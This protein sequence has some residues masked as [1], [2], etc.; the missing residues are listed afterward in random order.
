MILVTH[1]YERRFDSYMSVKC[2]GIW[3][4]YMTKP[5]YHMIVNHM[6]IC[7]FLCT[8]MIRT[9]MIHCR[10][11][12]LIYEYT[13][14]WRSYMIHFSSGMGLI[15]KETEGRVVFTYMCIWVDMYLLWTNY[16]G[17]YAGFRPYYVGIY[18]G[19]RP[20]IL[21]VYVDFRR[22]MLYPP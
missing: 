11:M 16:V 22:Y 8:H 4:S 2:V 12:T 15:V 14:I 19:F 21:H 18:V 6:I 1:T 13:D 5:D 20:C 9:Y 3:R 10:H 17:S 7:L